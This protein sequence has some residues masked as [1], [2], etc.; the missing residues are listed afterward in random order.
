[1][2]A[3]RRV[4]GVEIACWMT[5]GGFVE[6]RHCLVF[7]HGA[8]RNHAIWQYQ[9]EKLQHHFNTVALSLPGH[10]PSEGTGEES[11]GSYSRWVIDAI[12]A[13]GMRKPI[14]IGHSLG[15]AVSLDCASRYADGLSAI[16]LAGGGA[17]MPVNPMILEGVRR[18]PDATLA[19]SIKFGVARANRGRIGPLLTSVLYRSSP[20]VLYGDFLACDRFD[21]TDALPSIVLP[22]L[23]IC[24]FEDRLTPPAYTEFLGKAIR[25]SE[26]ALIE[27]AGHYAMLEKVDEFNHAL[28]GFL[29]GIHREV[30]SI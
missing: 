17:R 3:V 28:L 27:G 15:A 2:M 22:T 14:L 13:L 30:D 16:V 23:L 21:A 8:G 4:R 9:Y 29:G 11:V 1:M 25:G 24:G 26:I 20:D 12:L 19:L 5:D 7:I 10:R 6:G 18:D